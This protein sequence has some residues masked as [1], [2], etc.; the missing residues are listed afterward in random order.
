MRGV[1]VL[2]SFGVLA[3]LAGATAARAAAVQES[4]PG[5]LYRC[6]YSASSHLRLLL[7]E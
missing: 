2:A 4:V 3:L 5:L 6:S 7:F 1:L